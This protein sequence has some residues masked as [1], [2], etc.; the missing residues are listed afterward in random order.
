MCSSDLFDGSTLRNWVPTDF[1][2][3]GRVHVEPAFRDGRA[4][5]ILEKA[6]TLTGFNWAGAEKPP[7]TDYELEPE[8]MRLEGG[9]FF[10]GLTFPVGP[11]VCSLI[12]GGWGGMVVG[13]SSIDGDDASGNETT[14]GMEF[15]DHRWYRIRVRVTPAKLEA[16]IDD[17]PKIEVTLA[18]KRLSLRPGEIERSLPLGVAA[19]QTRAAIRGVRLRRL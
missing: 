3:G 19:Y 11:G 10:C 9:D 5:I 13:I 16:W 12:V 15:S 2:T 4:A 18:G 17:A 1:E 8:A 7:R 14:Q 6:P